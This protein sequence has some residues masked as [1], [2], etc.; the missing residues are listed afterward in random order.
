MR[1]AQDD[2]P[3]SPLISRLRAEGRVTRASTS[4]TVTV[5]GLTREVRVVHRDFPNGGS[6]SFYGC[7]HCGR[8]CRRVRLYEGQLR[9]PTCLCKLKVPYRVQLGDPEGVIARLRE[10]LSGKPLAL[11]GRTIH[12]KKELTASL[13]KAELRQRAKALGLK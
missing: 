8:R 2:L 6:W 13:R 5:G 7:P 9:C 1:L 12:R 11:S 4:V 10:K 3:S